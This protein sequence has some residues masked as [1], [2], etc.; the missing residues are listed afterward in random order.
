[1]SNFPIVPDHDVVVSPTL[2]LPVQPQASKQ[3]IN[4]IKNH[5]NALFVRYNLLLYEILCRNVKNVSS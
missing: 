5:R 4:S 2:N 3:D 1:M